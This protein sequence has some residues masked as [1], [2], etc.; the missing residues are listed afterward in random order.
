MAAAVAIA[1]CLFG[2]SSAQAGVLYSVDFNG[3][4]Q[5]SVTVFGDD[6]A[7]DFGAG[8]DGFRLLQGSSTTNTMSSSFD[9]APGDGAIVGTG[10][11]NS[12]H[13]TDYFGLDLEFDVA[14]ELTGLQFD[15]TTLNGA[16]PNFLV[17]LVAEDGTVTELVR[18]T[19]SSGDWTT[20]EYDFTGLD[21]DTGDWQLRF[22][23]VNN[24][25]SSKDLYFDNVYV[26]V[27]SGEALLAVPEPSSL[28]AP[29]VMTV[30]GLCVR[31]RRR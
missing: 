9:R 1:A 3:S 28:A 26:G 22:Y 4:N 23:G 12:N 20:Y 13:R 2:N 27:N 24:R 15:S 30:G 8:A 7:S 17:D 31:R 25:S 5:A 11:T 19:N 16:R 18:R 29:A 6:L 21:L 14:A 10:W